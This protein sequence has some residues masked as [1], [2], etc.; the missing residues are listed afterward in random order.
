[1]IYAQPI[2]LFEY[3]SA[4]IPAIASDFPMWRRIV[5]D[6]ACGICVDPEDPAA[7]AKAINSLAVD[8]RLAETLGAKGRRLVDERYNWTKEG[9]KL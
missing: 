5:V 2:K 4:G 1:H 3:M 6:E 8:H 7:I 9:E